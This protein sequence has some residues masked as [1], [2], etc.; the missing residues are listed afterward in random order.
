MR[1]ALLPLVLALSTCAEVDSPTPPM[2]LPGDYRTAF[3]QV[4][5]CRGTIEHGLDKS[6]VVRV[7]SEQAELY[8]AGPFPFPQGSLVVKEEYSDQGCTQLFN[9]TIMRKE[10]PGFF[11]EVGDWQWFRL[12]SYGTLIQGGKLADCSHCHATMCGSKRDYTCTEP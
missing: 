9:Y 12:D 6:V 4:R 1:L 10:A 3:V 2:V 5:G 7:R 11:P 8:N